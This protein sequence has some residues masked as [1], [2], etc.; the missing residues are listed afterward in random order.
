MHKLHFGRAQ[1]PKN[2]R[3]PSLLQ[4]IMLVFP[5]LTVFCV[6]LDVIFLWDPSKFRATSLL[7]HQPL[8][9]GAWGQQQDVLLCTNIPLTWVRLSSHSARAV[10]P[11]FP[12]LLILSSSL[13]IF[14]NACLQYHIT[15]S[16][17][18]GLRSKSELAT[19]LSGIMEQLSV[20]SSSTNK[21]VQLI[22]SNSSVTIVLEWQCRMSPGCDLEQSGV[23]VA[24]AQRILFYGNSYIYPPVFISWLIAGWFSWKPKKGLTWNPSSKLCS[25]GD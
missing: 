18:P 7:L 12:V 10:F 9:A 13:F 23:S 6:T 14:L 2:S 17:F 21:K 24:E 8:C 15:W 3:S 16:V 22:S 20:F 25:A 5:K 4:I 11:I 1:L 19:T